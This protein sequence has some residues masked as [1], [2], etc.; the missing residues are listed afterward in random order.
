[1]PL[2]RQR[3]AGRTKRR[4]SVQDLRRLTLVVFCLVLAL[5]RA[6]AGAETVT[7]VTWNLNWFP[8]GSP[9]SS[10][11]ERLIHMSAA[12]DALIDRHTDI[13]C[14]Q[15]VRDWE[16]VVELVSVLPSFQPLVV[17][18]FREFGGSGPVTIQQIAIASRWPSDSA[19]SESFKPAAASPPRGFSFAAIRRGITMP[20]V[21]SIHLKSNRAALD[22]D[23][24]KREEAT[25]QLLAHASEMERLYSNDA[26]VATVSA[27][28][29][30]T[31]S[32]NPTLKTCSFTQSGAQ[33]FAVFCRRFA[34]GWA[35]T[36]TSCCQ[37]VLPER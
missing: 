10:E 13:L 19:W 8:G 18:R 32:T 36:M 22:E 31:D 15:E 33:P 24:A 26:K 25:R 5:C 21:Y 37:S 17:S 3:P 14:L 28:D 6:L 35:Y 30:N 29:F 7:I 12:K 4:H 23:I 11:A 34:I 16:S 27:G 2:L 20:L 1:M 9:T